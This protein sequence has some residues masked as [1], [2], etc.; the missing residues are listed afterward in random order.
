MRLPTI[1]KGDYKL[2]GD[3]LYNIVTDPSE[4]NDIAA[5][6]AKLVK[7]LKARLDKMS[8]QRP[9][10]GDMSLLMT[11]AQPWVYGQQEN[12]NAPE[13]VKEIVR[14]VRATQPQEWAPGT[15]P[16]PQAPKDGK[17][18]YKGDGR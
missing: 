16:W 13:W 9:P 11:P 18:I 8:K 7:K 1:R 4:K 15:T 3:E 10:M 6:N 17:I 12:E 5:T 2:M 14:K